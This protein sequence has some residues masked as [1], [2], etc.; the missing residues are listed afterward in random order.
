MTGTNQIRLGIVPPTI[1]ILAGP[2]MFP[3]GVMVVAV[4]VVTAMIPAV[5]A[6]IG[7]CHASEKAQGASS[8]ANASII[9]A[10]GAVGMIGCEGWHSER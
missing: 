8:D 6:A 4:V 5:V 7:S 3:I 2:D 9:A 10:G 1:G